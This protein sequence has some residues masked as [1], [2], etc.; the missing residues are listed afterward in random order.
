MISGRITITSTM[1]SVARAARVRRLPIF[2]RNQRYSGVNR[3]A[4]AMP[5]NTAPKKGIRI[6]QKA[7]VTAKSRARNT[8]RWSEGEF[9]VGR[10]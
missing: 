8:P 7:A 4:S 2:P 3:I 5:Q 6:Q 10:M 1:P 9:M